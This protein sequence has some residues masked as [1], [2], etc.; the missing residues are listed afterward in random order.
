M[1][2][3]YITLILAVI[4]T[5]GFAQTKP[6]PLKV[7]YVSFT[8]QQ[9]MSIKSSVLKADSLLS[10]SDAKAKDILPAINVLSDLFTT[11]NNAYVRADTLQMV[12]LKKP[13]NK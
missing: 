12:P 2:H 10:I 1:K 11:F 6:K 5:A 4:V 13:S 7:Y 8:E 9:Y 3:L